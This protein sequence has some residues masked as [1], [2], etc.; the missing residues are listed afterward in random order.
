MP[1]F[2]KFDENSDIKKSSIRKKNQNASRTI[3]KKFISKKTYRPNKVA[4]IAAVRD[5]CVKPAAGISLNNDW[6]ESRSFQ[7]TVNELNT[8]QAKRIILSK[9]ASTSSVEKDKWFKNSETKMKAEVS[10]SRKSSRRKRPDSE[11][12]EETLRRKLSAISISS[13]NDLKTDSHA[14]LTINEKSTLKTAQSVGDCGLATK[15]TESNL[16]TSP[17]ISGDEN[18]SLNNS[19]FVSE[20]VQVD[21]LLRVYSD[22]VKSDPNKADNQQSS[23][24]ININQCKTSSSSGL[25][26]GRVGIEVSTQ[27]AL[28]NAS[29]I[30]K[31]SSK[32]KR[33]KKS[34]KEEGN[35]VNETPNRIIVVKAPKIEKEEKKRKKSAKKSKVSSKKMTS[36]Q[37]LIKIIRIPDNNNSPESEKQKEINYSEN[38][39]IFN[40]KKQNAS[41]N[42]EKH[43]QSKQRQ[44]YKSSKGH[45][46]DEDKRKKVQDIYANGDAKANHGKDFNQTKANYLTKFIQGSEQPE[47]KKSFK[48]LSSSEKYPP[49]TKS[50]SKAI[51]KVE[52]KRKFRDGINYI[53]TQHHNPV[54]R[55]SRKSNN[56]VENFSKEARIVGTLNWHTLA[57]DI[58][59]SIRPDLRGLRK[60]N[61]TNVKIRPPPKRFVK[62]SISSDSENSSC[63]STSSVSSDSA[64]SSYSDS[65]SDNSY[66][67]GSPPAHPNYTKKYINRSSSSEN[68]MK[69]PIARAFPRRRASSTSSFLQQPIQISN[70][71]NKSKH[72]HDEAVPARRPNTKLLTGDDK[73]TKTSDNSFRQTQNDHDFDQKFEKKRTKRFSRCI[74]AEGEGSNSPWHHHQ[75][76]VV[77]QKPGYHT[78]R[79]T[80]ITKSITTK[81]PSAALISNESDKH[82]Q[83][84]RDLYSL[85]NVLSNTQNGTVSTTSS[86]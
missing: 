75:L 16:T 44:H 72:K 77:S 62:P 25:V 35:K 53:Y 81:Q 7:Y 74:V 43:E 1:N 85:H 5:F 26:S 40:K 79:K 47:K 63:Y 39:D 59:D 22:D 32:S 37:N 52:D 56:H 18:Q 69:V 68:D 17:L 11:W 23:C 8:K 78:N 48:K 15:S 80:C 20:S 66:S 33:K 2:F 64:L 50:P 9:R 76:V 30:A 14:N 83:T 67:G 41:K 28:G 84:I 29:S 70:V 36:K 82:P 54:E 58:N 12:I 27:Q 38:E 3:R 86:L 24:S 10:Q 13:T 19:N 60:D 31:K 57:P 46:L 34:V 49:Q 4:A 21:N 61:S 42:R 45:K 55:S 6:K 71:W 65:S 51:N 73:T